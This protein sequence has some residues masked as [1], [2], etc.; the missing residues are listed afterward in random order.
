MH[1]YAI[2]NPR[3]WKVAY[4]CGQYKPR[5]STPVMHRLRTVP[6]ENGAVSIKALTVNHL[7]QLRNSLIV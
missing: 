7:L 2:F 3:G 5:T 1:S 4:S 6:Y